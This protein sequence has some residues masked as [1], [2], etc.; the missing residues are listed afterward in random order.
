MNRDKFAAKH[1]LPKCRTGEKGEG[2][3]IPCP[4]FGFLEA[5]GGSML[6]TGWYP[7]WTIDLIYNLPAQDHWGLI[8][9]LGFVCLCLISVPRVLGYSY[10]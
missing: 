7:R 4:A 8:V 9:H 5:L 6:E 3:C 1:Q 2:C 10:K